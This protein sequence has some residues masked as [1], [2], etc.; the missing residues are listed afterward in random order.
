MWACGTCATPEEFEKGTQG[1]SRVP[2]A[3]PQ[4]YN[5]P[6]VSAVLYGMQHRLQAQQQQQQLPALGQSS[7]SAVDVQ[8]V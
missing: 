1:G 5:N 2:H 3:D 4:G 8:V 7:A 6:V